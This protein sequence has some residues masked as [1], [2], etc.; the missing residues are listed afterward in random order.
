MRFALMIEAQMGLSYEDQL[1]IVRRAE[2]AGFEA[3][4]RSDHY[5]SFPGG[6]E[7]D[8]TDAWA[9]IAGLARE[10]STISARRPREPGDLPPPGQLREARDH[11][12]PH[13]RRP[14][15]GR[16]RRG[17]ERGG[18]RA[19]RPGVPGRSPSGQTSSRTSSRCCTGCGREPPAGRSRAPGKVRNGA[20]RPGPSRSRAGRRE[21]GRVRPRIITGERRLAARLPASPRKYSDE[22]N[23]SSASPERRAGRS[24][25]SSTRRA[26]RAGGTRRR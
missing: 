13:E 24:S 10:T 22:F 6:S 9:V 19:A 16:G 18:P 1:A 23:L 3:F 21:N 2:A 4:F 7:Q 25:A 8:T 14:D 15:R 5:A 26:A 11:R 12:R 17:L 20:L